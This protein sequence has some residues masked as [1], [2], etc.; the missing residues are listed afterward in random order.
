MTI[1]VFWYEGTQLRMNVILWMLAVLV[2]FIFYSQQGV[3]TAHALSRAARKPA[4]RRSG[5]GETFTVAPIGRVSAA[6][7]GNDERLTWLEN[8]LFA[9]IVG[10]QNLLPVDTQSQADTEDRVTGLHG[11]GSC[12]HLARQQC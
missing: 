4:G 5:F 2:G 1:L 11:V 3:A 7:S 8:T 10:G 12:R 9:E 6:G